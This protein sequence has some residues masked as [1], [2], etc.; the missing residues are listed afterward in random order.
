VLV[1][2][3]DGA[4]V[5]AVAGAITAATGCAART[6]G[7]FE[8]ISESYVLAKTGILVNFGITIAL[9]FVIGVL[10]AGQLLYNFVVENL[11]YHAALKAM[12]ATNGVLVRMVLTQALV[13]STIGFGI[14]VGGAALSGLALASGGLAF[15]MDWRI[16]LLGFAAILA[17]AAIAVLVSITRVLR[18]EPAVVF[19]G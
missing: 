6:R 3:R 17:V 10:V 8:G 19:K 9:G 15:E 11:R 4:D 2:V 7:E 1:K 18:L 12:G 16:P 14:G 13:A 5:A